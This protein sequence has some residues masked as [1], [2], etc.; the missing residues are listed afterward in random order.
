M[1]FQYH[2]NFFHENSTDFHLNFRSLAMIKTW[3]LKMKIWTCPLISNRLFC[4]SIKLSNNFVSKC[5]TKIKKCAGFSKADY[6]LKIPFLLSFDCA[7]GRTTFFSTPLRSIQDK[8]LIFLLWKV[9]FADSSP[10][11]NLCIISKNFIIYS[12]HNT[13]LKFT[14]FCKLQR[15]EYTFQGDWRMLIPK[16]ITILL[17]HLQFSRKLAE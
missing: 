4:S 3:C 6:F 7:H 14:I 8:V 13:D 17:D 10:T 12:S 16:I 2:T 9:S 5:G 11:E 1:S 15:P